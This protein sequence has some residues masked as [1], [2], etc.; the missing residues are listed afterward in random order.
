MMTLSIT[1]LQLLIFF[2]GIADFL[3]TFSSPNHETRT[4]RWTSNLDMDDTSCARAFPLENKSNATSTY[5]WENTDG[6]KYDNLFVFLRKRNM[7]QYLDFLRFSGFSS[8]ESRR[9]QC[10]SNASI[11]MLVGN[12]GIVWHPET[13]QCVKTKLKT[14]AV[15]GEQPNGKKIR[16]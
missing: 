12:P 7:M 16:D 15:S 1:V 3:P 11:F 10:Q 6:C 2:T 8:P 9:V 5:S 4:F 14:E 13:G